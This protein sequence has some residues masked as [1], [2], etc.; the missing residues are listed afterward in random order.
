MTPPKMPQE[1]SYYT[2]AKKWAETHDEELKNIDKYRSTQGMPPD[3]TPQNEAII[4][5]II[6][7]Q[8]GRT[9]K[10]AIEQRK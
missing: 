8:Y 6:I 7:Y 4:P 3:F 9:G 5:L 2:D 1:A 10:K